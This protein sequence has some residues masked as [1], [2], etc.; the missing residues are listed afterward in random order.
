MKRP[1]L[2]LI[3][4]TFL[5]FPVSEIRSQEK[6]SFLSFEASPGM[7]IPFGTS[8]DN[9]STGGFGV[10][11]VNY[12]PPITLPLYIGTEIGQSVAPYAM[13]IEK[14]LNLTSL[15][16]VSG[17]E[18]SLGRIALDLYAAGGYYYG[19]TEDVLGNRYSGG[20]PFYKLGV[21]ISWFFN[22]HFS[23]GLGAAYESFLGDPQTV[24]SGVTLQLKSSYRRYF[25][26][27]QQFVLPGPRKPVRLK[28]VNLRSDGIFPVFYQFYDEHPIGK[29]TLINNEPGKVEEIK[30]SVFIKNYMDSPKEYR[31]NGTLKEGE[32]RDIQLFALFN[33]QVLDITEGTKV[34]AE[35]SI[36]YTVRGNSKHLEHV[37]T[38]RLEHRNASIWDDDRRAAAFVTAKDPVILRFAKNL[39]GMARDGVSQA[40][41]YNMHIAMALHEALAVYGVDYVI[42][43][44]T[45]YRE[46]VKKAH[47]IDFLQFP[48]QTLEY[49]AGD[50]DDLS[51]LFAALLEAV[52]VDTAF[53]TVPGHIF[54]AFALDV[55]A[56]EIPTHFSNPQD[57]IIREG[58]AWVPLE[59]TQLAHG[60]LSS[61]ETG[62]NQWNRY[63][64]SNE[65]SFYPMEECWQVFEPVGLPGT[66][67]ITFPDTTVVE[68]GYKETLLL[69]VDNQIEN[70]SKLLQE[71]IRSS[72]GDYYF[73]NKLGVLYAKY[74]LYDQALQ[75]FTRIT[76]QNEY[77][78]ALVNIGNIYF[79]TNETEKALDYY[80]RASRIHPRNTKIL[81]SLLRVYA[82]RDNAE[83]ARETYNQLAQVDPD[84]ADD[85]RVFTERNAS[86]NRAG[87]D[88]S[89]HALA[90]ME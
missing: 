19:V 33:E 50:C 16:L 34:A 90:W 17:M 30:V 37:E 77:L 10:I 71:K 51:I 47:A 66:A 65:A 40:V 29:I 67:T 1:F 32:T 3:I 24:L 56:R 27:G 76:E 53:I 61:W 12:K 81:V 6:V 70:K 68:S 43:P 55:P 41:D 8:A 9:F 26:G 25:R 5:L 4:L 63:T 69:F 60:F 84:L 52:S 59:V 72:G 80:K 20:N 13:E 64:Q 39:A 11:G 44:K 79:L 48:R 62:I 21:G 35:L 28:F 49:K 78:P 54:I 38:V 75:Q 36:D 86:A 2:Y 7:Q 88:G 89:R 18:F 45:P 14:N 58:K 15:G 57:F 23:L 87:M 22:Q 74:A 83:Q 73:I 46:Y 85:Y 42:D 82:K 31:L